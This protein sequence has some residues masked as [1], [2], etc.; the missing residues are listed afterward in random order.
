MN[1]GATTD[2]KA[3]VLKRKRLD[4]FDVCTSSVAT[5]QKGVTYLIDP[6]LSRDTLNQLKRL[7]A[8]YPRITIFGVVSRV[9]AF[10]GLRE[11]AE[12]K[13]LNKAV[14]LS[15]YATRQYGDRSLRVLRARKSKPDLTKNLRVTREAK[16]LENQCGSTFGCSMKTAKGRL[17]VKTTDFPKVFNVTMKSS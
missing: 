15:D 12:R 10:V 3:Q 14:A 6:G 2:A 7:C 8:D 13:S 16:E 11:G 4:R 5:R 9:P 1:V 17:G